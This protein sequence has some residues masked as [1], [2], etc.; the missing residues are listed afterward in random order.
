MSDLEKCEHAFLGNNCK[1]KAVWKVVSECM[2]GASEWNFYCQKHVGKHLG[3]GS[4]TY[5]RSEGWIKE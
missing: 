3:N 5:L 4:E 1:E 2:V